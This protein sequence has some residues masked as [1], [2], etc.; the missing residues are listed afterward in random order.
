MTSNLQSKTTGTTTTESTLSELTSANTS[1]DGSDEV[2]TEGDSEFGFGDGVLDVDSVRRMA[3]SSPATSTIESSNERMST[4]TDSMNSNDDRSMSSPK[5]EAESQNTDPKKQSS[6]SISQ[7]PELKAGE[8]SIYSCLQSF[9]AEELL[10]GANM[11]ACEKC[12]RPKKPQ[13][14]ESATDSGADSEYHVPPTPTDSVRSMSTDES[15]LGSLM[16]SSF[17]L[18]EEESSPKVRCPAVKQ[19]L[20][21]EPG[22]LLTL[23]LKRFEQT[24]YRVEKVNKYVKFPMQL[25]ISPFCSRRRDDEEDNDNTSGENERKDMKEENA[26]YLYNLYGVV[27]HQGRINSGHYTSYVKKLEG[28]GKSSW[29][30]IS[31]AMTNKVTEATVLKAQAYLLFYERA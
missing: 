20:M 31:D 28:N 7:L 25:D 1:S 9:C 15:G 24:G 8:Y 2:E 16:K 14:H 11:Y 26:S 29:Y 5:N 13:D 19:I 30:H 22:Q 3:Q 17:A 12:C 27:V 21:K 23:H 6:A 10:D 18:M 4:P